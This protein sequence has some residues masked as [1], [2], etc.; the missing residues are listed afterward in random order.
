MTFAGL[1]IWGGLLGWGLLKGRYAPFVGM[2]L[3]LLVALNVRYFIEGSAD[4]IA[5]FVGLYDVADNIG[6]AEG[7]SA[8]AMATCA[9][10]ACSVMSDQ[11]D[12]H[13]AWGVAFYE[14]FANGSGFRN[15]MLYTHIGFNTI[16]FLLMHLQ[17]LRPGTLHAATHRMIGRVTFG[18][19]TI[20]T[21]A[22]V[23]LSSQHSPV[24]EYGGVGSML[25]F[26][27]MSFVVYG[28]AVMTVRTIRQGDVEAHRRWTFLFA[29][30]MWG[31]FWLFRAALLVLG[32]LL[33]NYEAAA[34]QTVIWGSA[35]A[36]VAI[37][38]AILR[39]RDAGKQVIALD[40]RTPVAV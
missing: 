6:L 3:A 17:M 13:P 23:I 5:F 33:R 15:A 40:E 11:Y 27:S 21:L 4:G 30:S 25:G 22:A 19:I 36:G 39:R 31:A 35:P 24:N 38:W 1:G 12:Q 2:G 14:R 7:E 34:L 18:A 8:A 28:C 32:P 26:Y 37:A 29:G 9:D 16:A 10:G 20:G